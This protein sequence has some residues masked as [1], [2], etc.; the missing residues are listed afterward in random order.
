M[1]SR[2]QYLNKECTH[3][4]YYGQFVTG[5]VKSAVRCSIGKDAIVKSN[6]PHFNDIP[7]AKWDRL[8]FPVSSKKIKEAGDYLTKAGFVCIAKEAARQIKEGN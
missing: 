6:D 4:E 7:L 1:F 3:A 2:Q 8:S 5:A